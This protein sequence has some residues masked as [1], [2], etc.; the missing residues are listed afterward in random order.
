[1]PLSSPSLR[2][3]RSGISFKFNLLFPACLRSHVWEKREAT[4]ERVKEEGGEIKRRGARITC[5]CM[6]FSKLILNCDGRRHLSE[7][8]KVPMNH[9]ALAAFSLRVDLT[10]PPSPF[11]MRP[12]CVTLSLFVSLPSHVPVSEHYQRHGMCWREMKCICHRF[13]I[14]TLILPLAV[15]S[16]A[17]SLRLS[18]FLCLVLHTLL[19][20]LITAAAVQ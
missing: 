10:R 9:T 6:C 14:Y 17:V 20:G 16:L 3:S 12:V 4:D 7:A 15:L 19:L 8:V 13:P 11:G 2:L 5:Y 1:M 18:R